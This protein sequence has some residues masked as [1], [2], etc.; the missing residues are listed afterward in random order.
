MNG[1]YMKCYTEHNLFEWV[2][3]VILL[4]NFELSEGVTGGVLW[5]KV[6]LKILQVSQ[7][8]ASVRVSL[9]KLQ[10]WRPASLLKR[11]SNTGAFLWNLQNF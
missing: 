8:N 2:N 10:A 6:F 11:G 1:F 3:L 4:V 7:E 9:I 5:K